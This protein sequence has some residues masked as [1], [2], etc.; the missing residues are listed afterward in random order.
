L[1]SGSNR[2]LQAMNRRYTVEEY[3]QCI[4]SIRRLSPQATFSTDVIVGFPGETREEF[5][6]TRQ[7]MQQLEYDMAYIFRYSPRE[8]TRAAQT[9]NDDVPEEQK[10]ERNQILL[11]DLTDSV[12]KR[13][14]GYL[15]QTVEVLVEG[16]SK[17]NEKRWTGRTDL[18]KVCIFPPVDGVTP[19]QLRRVKICRTTANSLFGDIMQA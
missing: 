13:N 12:E 3:R 9:M 17:R 14:K 2:I 6:Q 7:M 16:Q 11:N 19:G 5:E 18:N 10:M 1:Q 8:G 4:E 15:A